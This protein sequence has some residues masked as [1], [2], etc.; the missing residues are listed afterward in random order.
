MSLKS[1]FSSLE[2]GIQDCFKQGHK[3]LSTFPFSDFFCKYID[4]LDG[5]PQTNIYMLHIRKQ[6]DYFSWTDSQCNCNQRKTSLRL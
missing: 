6:W 4:W 5:A 3:D 2:N 1:L